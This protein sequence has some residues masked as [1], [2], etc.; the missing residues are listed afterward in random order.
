MARSRRQRALARAPS[1]HRPI[2]VLLVGRTTRHSGGGIA[3]SAKLI[4]QAL[5]S[6]G[7]TCRLRSVEEPLTDIPS[8]TD[9]VWHYGDLTHID[10][11]VS[12]CREA[13]VPILINST[14]DDRYDR[15]RFMFY[16][17]DTWGDIADPSEVFLAVFSHGGERDPR[18]RKLSRHLVSV[19]KTIDIA[20]AGDQ[21]WSRPFDSRSGICLGE[22]EKLRR[23]RLVAGIDVDDA[24]AALQRVCPGVELT[25][26]DQYG[27]DATDV[28][29]G[30]VVRPKATTV[31]N[32]KEFFDW[33]GGH[34]LFVSLV[35]F[36]TF[37]MVPA[38]AQAV[39]VPVLYRHMPQSLNEHLGMT[40]ARF[41]TV[42]E[43]AAM[44][45]CLY[46]AKPHWA[47]MSYA[48]Y[49][50]ANA[51]CATFVGPAL[52]LSLRRL[53]V[54]AGKVPKSGGTKS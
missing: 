42:D 24:V 28:P 15:R 6:V 47:K 9:L 25:V 30:V 11:M 48:G 23:R 36:E 22:L 45:H 18:L 40:G 26:Y 14:L 43:L 41:D 33:L 20:H 13:R 52:S 1:P 44:A 54:R 35:R 34:R 4:V 29:K 5:A 10:Q 27:T 2:T 37:A 51:R 12:A 31:D 46:Y 38:E 8:D 17:M 19:P 21:N 39:G 3:R 49:Q 7:D 53:L 50:N 16:Q 32:R